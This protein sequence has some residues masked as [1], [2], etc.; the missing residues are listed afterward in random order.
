MKKNQLMMATMEVKIV[1]VSCN[2]NN[3]YIVAMVTVWE[4]TE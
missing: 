1:K 4:F 2:P 3:L